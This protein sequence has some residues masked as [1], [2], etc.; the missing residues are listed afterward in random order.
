MGLSP[1]KEGEDLRLVGTVPDRIVRDTFAFMRHL[2]E[3]QRLGLSRD[4]GEITEMGGCRSYCDLACLLRV[5]K[6]LVSYL[7]ASLLAARIMVAS[8]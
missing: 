6:N 5:P 7:C 3:F 8:P 4:G 2:R 1:V